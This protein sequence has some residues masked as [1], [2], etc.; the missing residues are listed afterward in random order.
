MGHPSEL[1]LP[2]EM[3]TAEGFSHVGFSHVLSG[4]GATVY[5]DSE[6]GNIG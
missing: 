2:V 3:S 4:E 5:S 1:C 6:R